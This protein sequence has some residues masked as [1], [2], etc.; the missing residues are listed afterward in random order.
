MKKVTKADIL[1]DLT[2]NVYCRIKPSAM[3]GVGVFAIKLIPKG[4]NPF[5]TIRPDDV[6]SVHIAKDKIF[7]N[8][9]IDDEVKHMVRDFH[10][11]RNGTVELPAMGM[12]ELNISYFMNTSKRPN[13]GTKTGEEFFALRDIGKGEELTV[14]YAQFSDEMV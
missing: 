7:E 3:H 10:T 5:Q 9:D 14:D 8:P 2:H 4:T 12:N 11:L 1:R 13:I 6:P